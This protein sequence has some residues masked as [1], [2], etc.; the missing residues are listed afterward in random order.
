LCK[1]LRLLLGAQDAQQL[2]RLRLGFRHG[3]PA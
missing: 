2:R 3:P 1:T